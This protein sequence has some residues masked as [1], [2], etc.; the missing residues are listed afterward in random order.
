MMELYLSGLFNEDQENIREYLNNTVLSWLID[1][2]RDCQLRD[3]MMN[4]NYDKDNN[5]RQ[6][7]YNN[8]HNN[9]NIEERQQIE[10]TQI[11]AREFLQVSKY[12]NSLFF[13]IIL[14]LTTT[15][16]VS[17]YF[18]SWIIIFHTEELFQYKKKLDSTTSIRLLWYSL[19]L[20]INIRFSF[21]QI[22]PHFHLK[23]Y[24]Y[25]G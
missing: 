20:I 24:I 7:F 18:I 8:N 25:V 17:F 16:I 5:E 4:V 15:R 11:F 19:R 22:R 6:I 2:Q 23:I 9:S 13:S 3:G 10:T 12:L 1:D 14:K 21:D